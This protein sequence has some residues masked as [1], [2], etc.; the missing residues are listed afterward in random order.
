M[1]VSSARAACWRRVI[2]DP[3]DEGDAV[4]ERSEHDGVGHGKHGRRI[5]D[6]PVVP[7]VLRLLEQR[8]HLLGT[9]QL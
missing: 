7:A 6:D 3:I 1:S 8:P 9:E 4:D 2:S 5:D